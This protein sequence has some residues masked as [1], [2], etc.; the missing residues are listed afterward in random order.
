MADL[1]G[2]GMKAL[3][4]DLRGNSGGLLTGAVALSERFLPKGSKIVSV[5]SKIDVQKKEYLVES[6][7]PK[8]DMPMVVL[9]NQAS[10]SAS[11]IFSAAMQDHGRGVIVG[12]KTFGKAS[13]QSVV[14]LDERS[15]LRLT[16]A[17]Y[18]SP[19]G[20]RIDAVGL[21]PDHVVPDEAGGQ[22]QLQI[23]KAI[24]LLKQYY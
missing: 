9:V 16:T 11:E 17:R 12:M 8:Y 24:D 3:I 21:M 22:N 5:N 1:K 4:V 7:S 6:E 10:A 13:V 2:R 23:K 19:K 14:P 18:L 20:R 15:A